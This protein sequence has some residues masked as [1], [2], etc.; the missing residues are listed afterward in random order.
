M[1]C[2]F[3]LNFLK[4][5]VLPP[6]TKETIHLSSVVILEDIGLYSYV[7]L[8]DGRGLVQVKGILHYICPLL[9]SILYIFKPWI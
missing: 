8:I 3:Y 4:K 5:I 9:G 7:L 2:G 6:K 1:S